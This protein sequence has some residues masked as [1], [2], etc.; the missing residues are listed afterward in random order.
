[1]TIERSQVSEAGKSQRKT[2]KWSKGSK[3][4][5]DAVSSEEVQSGVRNKVESLVKQLSPSRLKQ[6]QA[7]QPVHDV[8]LVYAGSE[9]SY[10]TRAYDDVEDV[11]LFEVK[12]Y[13]A[14]HYDMYGTM[15]SLTDGVRPATLERNTIKSASAD[16]L[17]VLSVT[18]QPSEQPTSND[19]VGTS[20]QQKPKPPKPLPRAKPRVERRTVSNKD[21]AVQPTLKSASTDP[22]FVTELSSLLK[23]RNQ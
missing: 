11:E 4:F 18:A 6:S 20:E 9:E 1:V 23:Q 13:P 19:E 8:K 10:Q 21:T 22:A 7:S 2:R 17:D 5:G 16:C 12:R 14:Y 15:Y 3:N